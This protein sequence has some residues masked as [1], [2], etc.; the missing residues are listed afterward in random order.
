MTLHV[1]EIY[2]AMIVLF[3]TSDLMMKT[4]VFFVLLCVLDFSVSINLTCPVW[5]FYNETSN[6]CQCGS[7]LDGLV[8]CVS[9]ENGHFSV[10]VLFC[11][12]MT[13]NQRTKEVTVGQC[14][15]NCRFHGKF[16]CQGKTMLHSE[17][18]RDL[19]WEVCG[20]INRAGHLCGDCIEGYGP[21]VYSY[22]QD[23]VK[24]NQSDYKFN[25]MKYIVIAY[26][27]LTLFYLFIILFKISITS[28]Q[29][30][31][32]V[33]VCQIITFPSFLKAYFAT[34]KPNVFLNI[35]LSGI[36]LW[37]MDFFRSIYA[38][39]CL[40]SKLNR[41]HVVA[42]DYLVAIY[43]LFLILVTYIAV[44]LHDRYPLI[45][46]ICKPI[47]K[48]FTFIRKEWS[49]RGSLIQGFASFLVLS[50]VKI[51]NVSFELLSFVRPLDVN[52]GY[53][54]TTYLYMAGTLEYFALEHLP[55]GI[56]AV[57]MFTV[58]NI[59]PV[60]VIFLYPYHW[61]RRC[62]LWGK[63]S[64][65]LHF[66]MEAFHGYYKSKPKYY[67]SF[68]AA[69]FV[70][71]IVEQIFFSAF[72]DL[73]F[74]FFTAVNLM[75]MM[76]IVILFQ[77]YKNKIYNKV[78]FLL[79]FNVILVFFI[80]I[81]HLYSHSYEPKFQ[82]NKHLKDLATVV[83]DILVFVLICYGI[84]IAVFKVTTHFCPKNCFKKIWI[85]SSEELP[86]LS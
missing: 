28:H 84:F 85:K 59:A 25:I 52:G 71:M 39:F 65:G 63:H 77:P 70:F 41:M 57:I 31:A 8:E 76:S 23:C 62:F 78:A 48:F 51:L 3:A 6:K 75:I 66:L 36:S 67:Q 55:F 15:K 56:L 79:F 14:L 35:F 19:N 44:V 86:I 46:F 5:T 49:I 53:T 34:Q 29:M 50:Y 47:H 45:V 9:S 68:A 69:Y 30:I 80:V 4:L 2:L 64:Q 38:P 1:T 17:D 20:S 27:P 60:V 16:H 7:S 37:N 72:E 61:F 33:F 11:Y 13:Y 58:F 10:S 18:Y 40:H 22:L 26:G 43:P 24:C 42:L 32:F 81:F 82:N 12:C 73:S 54:N 21:P 74:C 83:A